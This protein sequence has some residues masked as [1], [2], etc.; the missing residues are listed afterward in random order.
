M[1]DVYI[2]KEMEQEEREEMVLGPACRVSR[3]DVMGA[4]ESVGSVGWNSHNVLLRQGG[5]CSTRHTLIPEWVK[6]TKLWLDYAKSQPVQGCPINAVAS[7][8]AA[9]SRLVADGIMGWW[10]D[11]MMRMPFGQCTHDLG[12]SLVFHG[13]RLLDIMPLI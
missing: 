9:R 7:L 4:A 6:R 12:T 1:H 8:V 10:D 13:D 3:W 2:V 5:I 11:E